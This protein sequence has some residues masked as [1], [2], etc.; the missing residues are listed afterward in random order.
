MGWASRNPPRVC[1]DP[2]ISL[3]YH[4]VSLVQ[5]TTRLLPVTRDLVS[6]PLGG[7]YVNPGFPG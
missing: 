5:W 4:L 2:A 7:T 3:H 1:A 6:N